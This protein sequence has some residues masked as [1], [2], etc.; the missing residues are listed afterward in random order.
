MQTHIASRKWHR[1]RDHLQCSWTFVVAIAQITSVSSDSSVSNVRELASQWLRNEFSKAVSLNFSFCSPSITLHAQ[2]AHNQFVSTPQKHLICNSQYQHVRVMQEPAVQQIRQAKL[3]CHAETKSMICSVLKWGLAMANPTFRASF[4]MPTTTCEFSSHVLLS[5]G[6]KGQ[7]P[8]DSHLISWTVFDFA[9]K[10][11]CHGTLRPRSN[12]L[13]TLYT[14]TC[15]I[16][17]SKALLLA[18][19]CST[20]MYGSCQ[21]C[22]ATSVV[23]PFVSPPFLYVFSCN[24]L[25]EGIG[26]TIDWPAG[27][28]SS[29]DMARTLAN[30]EPC[31]KRAVG[32]K[33]LQ[34]AVKSSPS[35]KCSRTSV[36]HNSPRAHLRRCLVSWTRNRNEPPHCNKCI[37]VCLDYSWHT[38][39]S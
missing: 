32:G 33:A 11:K 22:L 27:S 20:A 16:L 1:K 2:R 38:V 14:C 30:T 23:T 39:T 15:T 9:Q 3:L 31:R 12:A 18:T 26:S 10:S 25:M 36:D 6:L 29:G 35:G 13:S 5:N 8:G 34:T 17:H 28:T 37:T 4:H 24:K 19:Q 21:D 7:T